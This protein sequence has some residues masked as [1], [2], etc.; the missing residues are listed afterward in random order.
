MGRYLICWAC[1]LLAACQSST[2]D[3]LSSDPRSAFQKQG[4]AVATALADR[5]A[6]TRKDCGSASKP[7]FLCAGILF[8]GTIHSTQYH[9]WNP[10][11]IAVE[12]G[13]LSFSYLRRDSQYR[14]IDSTY[15]HGFV[16]HPILDTPVGKRH[17]EVL[18]VFPID[19]ATFDRENPGCGAHRAYPQ[20]SRRCQSQGITTAEQWMAHTVRPGVAQGHYQCSF[21]VRDQM[22]DAAADAFYQALRVMTLHQ[23][24]AFHSRNELM[25]ATW[26]QDI[27][28]EL[29]IQALYYT[30]GGLTSAQYDQQDFYDRS[31]LRLPIIRIELPQTPAHQ[32]RFVFDPADQVFDP[33]SKVLRVASLTASPQA[34]A[35]TFAADSGFPRTGFSG[36]RYRL[37]MAGGTPPFAFSSAEPGR[38][39]I[40]AGTGEVTLRGHGPVTFTIKDAGGQSVQ[41]TQ[42]QATLWFTALACHMDWASAERYANGHG[43]ALPRP[44]ELNGGYLLRYPGALYP[45]WGDLVR[46]YGWPT[47]AFDAAHNY[48]RSIP[49]YWTAQAASAGD[50]ATA[51]V[52][53][54][55]AHRR[56]AAWRL[57]S[58]AVS[59]S[60]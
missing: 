54:G 26:P 29:P 42:P 32:A 27:P 53:L 15:D 44:L 9:F 51:A 56:P 60:P 58:V 16:F 28:G 55:Y 5:Y 43:V 7:A 41:Y 49:E 59:R 30:G 25:L 18:C 33:Q 13:G 31:G 21:D 52:T 24:V 47:G 4:E 11:P 50:Y 8:R 36:A 23:D 40:G 57:C 46:G 10:S 17:I 35:F 37:N 1:L 3:G 34:D 19:G 20:Q 2:L 14:Q 38:A 45:E 48:D 22:N 6:D 12:K 39:E